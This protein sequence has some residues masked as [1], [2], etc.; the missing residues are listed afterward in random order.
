[1]YVSTVRLSGNDPETMAIWLP[2]FDRPVSCFAFRF[3]AL[4]DGVMGL[5]EIP[6]KDVDDFIVLRSLEHSASEKEPSK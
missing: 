5:I 4:E 6:N 2:R 3:V 1:M